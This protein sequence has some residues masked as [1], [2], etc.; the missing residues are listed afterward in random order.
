MLIHRILDRLVVAQQLS[1]THL[2][3]ISTAVLSLGLLA[4]ASIA[5][6]AEIAVE[7]DPVQ[8]DRVAFYEVHWG[9]ESGTYQQSLSSTSTSATLSGLAEGQTLYIAARACAEGG[10]TCSDF[11]NELSAT[12]TATLTATLT[13][14]TAEF[15]VAT[16]SGA[17]PLAVSF[18]NASTGTIE[19]YSWDF[20]DGATSQEASPT[21][22]YAQP[23]TYSPT[24]RVTGPAGSAS[25]TLANAISV[26]YAAPVAGF[27]ESATSGLAPLT[28]TFSNTSEGAVD[29]CEWD[30]GDGSTA[31]GCDAA[32]TFSRVGT[33]S[34]TLTVQ[35]PGGTDILSKANLIT[36]AALPPV[37][38]FTSGERTGEAPLTLSFVSTSAGDISGYHWDFGDGSTSSEVNP[39][40]TY[41]MVGSYDVSLA[42]SGPGGSD[43]ALQVDYVEVAAAGLPIEVGEV[44]VDD[45]WQ[46][47]DFE[48]PFTDPVVVAKPAS[49]NGWDP[50]TV[51]IDGI[52]ENGF[53]IRL[54]EWD[55][56]D[57][58]HTEETVSY[59]AMERGRHQLPSGAWIEADDVN[60]DAAQKVYTHRLNAPFATVPVMVAGVASDNDTNA[61]TARLGNITQTSFDLGLQ[62]QQSSKHEHGLERVAYVAWEPSM[63]TI[64]GL[65]FEVAQASQAVTEEVA[66][67]AFA[68]VYASAPQVLADM[69]TLNSSDPANLR[70][71]Y[72]DAASIDLAVVEEQSRNSQMRHGEE[73]VGYI[74]L[75][76]TAQ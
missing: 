24:L 36:S 60:I 14:P 58:A 15:T 50:T 33:F 63:G 61:V 70:W 11:S 49:S 29:A 62:E 31:T 27:T 37:A 19:G 56:L 67:I 12:T 54:Q 10:T 55:Y 72:K 48:T 41:T 73:R 13:E 28:V 17:A 34:V 76:D 47:V 66:S 7:W 21:H 18:S 59:I 20:G 65:E 6:S 46:R 51:R 8:D 23:G 64:D 44:A 69:Q 9:T 39:T 74:L 42:V 57:G 40:H 2:R 43:T 38:A 16:T 22:V 71:T 53:W 68:K 35:G 1:T 32:K 26:G 30:F 3:S 45:R 75:H 5:S 25:A 52:D 4:S